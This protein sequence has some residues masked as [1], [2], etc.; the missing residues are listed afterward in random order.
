MVS[1]A[2]LEEDIEVHKDVQ[3]LVMV[4]I[5]KQDIYYKITNLNMLFII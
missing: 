1:I 5:K 4:Q 2:E 3:R